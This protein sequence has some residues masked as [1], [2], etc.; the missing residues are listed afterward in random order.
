ML[1][2]TAYCRASRLASATRA[3]HTCSSELVLCTRLPCCWPP[4]D[5][6]GPS[7]PPGRMSGCLPSCTDCFHVGGRGVPHCHTGK[8]AHSCSH[9]IAGCGVFW[10]SA[11]LVAPALLD[12][13]CATAQPLPWCTPPPPVQ[14]TRHLGFNPWH[15]QYVFITVTLVLL[16]ALSLPI[17]GTNW[18]EA[19]AG[20]TATDWSVLAVLGSVINIGTNLT[21]QREPT[22]WGLRMSRC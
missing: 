13:A 12:P 18:G 10:I 19:L 7:D 5:P 11:G 2:C 9:G 20:W 3:C 8:A 17:N 16:L 6:E 1:Y 4:T 15:L 22:G 21:M 14:A